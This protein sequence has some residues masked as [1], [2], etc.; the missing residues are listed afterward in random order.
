MTTDEKIFLFDKFVNSLLSRVTQLESKN[1]HLRWKDIILSQKSIYLRSHLAENSD[2]NL[3]GDGYIKSPVLQADETTIRC[4]SSLHITSSPL[5]TY[6]FVCPQRGKIAIESEGSIL[7]K[8]R[9]YFMYNSSYWNLTHNH[10]ICNA[11]IIRELQALIENAKYYD[12]IQGFISAIR[13]QQL[14]PFQNLKLVFDKQFQSKH[15]LDPS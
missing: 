14:N 1:D 6:F 12:R 5:Y 7:P 2:K 13:K 15:T 4:Q 11:H 9:N 8:F 3:L 10:L